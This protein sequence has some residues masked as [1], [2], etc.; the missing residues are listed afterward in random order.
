MG[1][2]GNESKEEA[3]ERYRHAMADP[4]IQAILID[5]NVRQFLKDL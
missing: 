2:G 4:D 1:A 3:E 5:P